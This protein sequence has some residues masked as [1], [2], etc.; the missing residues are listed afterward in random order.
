MDD[1]VSKGMALAYFNKGQQVLLDDARYQLA[2]QISETEWQLENLSTGRMKDY[3]LK[4]LHTLY[5]A[6]R[7]RFLVNSASGSRA[8]Y[9]AVHGERQIVALDLLET[10]LQEETKRRYAYV[11]AVMNARLIIYTSATINPIIETVYRQINDKKRKPNWSTVNRWRKRFIDGG[12][13]IRAMVPRNAMKGNRERRVPEQVIE[14]VRKAVNEKYMT[15]E[16][17]TMIDTRDHAI[18]L[19]NDENKLLPSAARLP[20]PT[21][22]MVKSVIGEIDA[23]DRSLARDGYPIAQAKFRA[24][25]GSVIADKPLQRV[26]ID[27]TIFDVMLIDDDSLLPL[28]RPTVTACIEVRSRCA[29]GIYIGFEP[30]S[31]DTVAQCLKH[32]F[33]PKTGLREMYPSVNNEWEAYGVMETL[34]VDNGLEFHSERLEAMCFPFGINIQYSP[35][36]KPWFKPYIERFLGSLNRGTAHGMPGTTFANIFEKADYDATKNA[37]LTL[38]QFKEVVNKWVVDYYHQQLHRTLG[39]KPIDVWREEANPDSIPFPCDVNELDFLLG[40]TE[41]RTVTHKGVELNSLFYNSKSLAT[42]RAKHGDKLKA[43]IRYQPSDLGCIYVID[44]DNGN[45][46]KVPALNAEYASGL[47]LW[48]HKII[49]RYAREHLDSEDIVALAEAKE[50]I[51]DIVRGALNDKKLKTRKKAARYK[52]SSSSDGDVGGRSPSKKTANAAMNEV[53][54][55]D[56]IEPDALPDLDAPLARERKKFNVIIGN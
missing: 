37:V 27:H 45:S 39:R 18:K 3:T 52:A 17:P 47:S 8:D 12:K 53:P 40:A 19:V 51:R 28:G 41:T 25:L 1:G 36:K 50:A 26:E 35:R 10:E 23:Y 29:L 16:K 7:L 2:R 13:D 24:V 5:T 31:A 48:S 4:E 55:D 33:L 11:K 44:P 42:L 56:Q 14:I 49:R 21:A 20:L 32:A 30:P 43:N 34:V 9:M 15:R 38:S 6:G 22:T 54:V 46:L